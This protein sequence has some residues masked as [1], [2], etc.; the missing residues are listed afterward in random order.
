MAFF[1]SEMFLAII[2]ELGMLVLAGLLLTLSLL[3]NQRVNCCLGRVTAIGSALVAVLA[4][5]FSMPG[6]DPT[7]LWGGMLRLDSAGFLFR[8]L[9]LVGVSLTAIFAENEEVIRT[10]PEFYA[11]LVFSAIGMS[12]MA[13]AGD[14]IM[15]FLAIEIASIPLYVLAGVKFRNE[16]SVEAGIKYFLFGSLASSIMVFGFSILY[17]MG[18]TTQINEIHAAVVAANVPIAG[19]VGTVLL[20]LAGFTFKISA[21]P[22]HWWAPDVYE[23]APT[24]VSGFL[25]TASKAAGFAIMLRLMSILFSAEHAF[26]WQLLIAVIAFASMFGGNLVAISQKN[27]KRLLAYSSIAQAGYIL[28]GVAA[29][30]EFGY[31]AVVYYL[32]VYLLTN[33][34]LFAVVGWVEKAAGS[35]DLSSFAGLHKRSPITALAILIGLLSLGGIP[36]FGGFFAKLLVFGAAID[37]NLAWLAIIGIVNSVISLYYYLRVLKMMYV[38]EPAGEV[39]LKS[40][41]LEFK[42]VLIVCI[43][44]IIVFG[45]ILAPWFNIA[46]LAAGGI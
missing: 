12:F 15:L 35:A 7:F 18:G 22:F 11:M 10:R 2:P 38:D 40:P 9:F 19:L 17:G 41:S 14:L 31:T 28:V 20:I 34:M 16:K 26:I 24:P 5:I 36:P 27:F 29:G 8:I 25:S 30:T 46:T 37:S 44:G 6:T 13:S 32:M 4:F 21:V 3:K 42:I 43:T 33:L 45:V 23:G 1:R 39:A